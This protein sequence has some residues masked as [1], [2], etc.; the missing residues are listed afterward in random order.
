MF[1]IKLK[2]VKKVNL[3]ASSDKLSENLYNRIKKEIKIH[4]VDAGLEVPFLPDGRSPGGPR[5]A[6]PGVIPR[7]SLM[8]V[9]Q[10][11][12]R[13]LSAVIQGRRY[14]G[15]LSQ[16]A[17]G[18]GDFGVALEPDFIGR[19]QLEIAGALAHQ[20]IGRQFFPDFSSAAEGRR[21]SPIGPFRWRYGR[22]FNGT[23]R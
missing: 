11:I 9:L 22:G 1:C 2:K 6:S 3:W 18:T 16:I 10:R 20:L 5:G 8:N 21:K 4:L 12:G 15:G 13:K 14:P 19:R 17:Q 23:G 7:V